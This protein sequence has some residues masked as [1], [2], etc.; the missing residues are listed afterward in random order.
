MF[1]EINP[2]DLQPEVSV[3][4]VLKSKFDEWI[5]AFVL[6]AIITIKFADSY[7][8]FVTKYAASAFLVCTG[9]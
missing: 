5:S 3:W 1:G 6:C 9:Q 4:S 2:I 8:A 7:T